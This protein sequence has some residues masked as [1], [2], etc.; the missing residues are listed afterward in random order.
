MIPAKLTFLA[1]EALVALALL[2][3][4]YAHQAGWL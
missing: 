4:N 2:A 3:M 1:L